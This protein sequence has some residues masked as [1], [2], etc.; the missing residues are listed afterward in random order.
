MVK[1]CGEYSRIHKKN[2]NPLQRLINLSLAHD[3]YFWK[4]SAI[5]VYNLLQYFG[6]TQADAQTAT[7]HNLNGGN[8]SET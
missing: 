7:K 2:P 4:I 5:Y 1:C 3:H 8:N 6:E